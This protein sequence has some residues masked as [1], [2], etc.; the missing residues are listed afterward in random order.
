MKIKLDTYIL[1]IHFFRIIILHLQFR[2]ENL[3]A[4]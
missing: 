3:I 4:L 2:T 1:D